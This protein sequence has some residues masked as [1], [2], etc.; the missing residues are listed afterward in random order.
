M[1]RV[2]RTIIE[3]GDDLDR[4]HGLL[5]SIIPFRTQDIGR[6][7]VD[8][9]LIVGIQ[10]LGIAVKLLR[11][12]DHILLALPWHIAVLIFAIARRGQRLMVVA[13]QAE[14]AARP[15]ELASIDVSASF[16]SA[17]FCAAVE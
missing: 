11:R 2:R 7:H 8:A 9:E 12:I 15:Q 5:H 13:V 4:W 14:L 16:A 1:Q 10:A 6:R 3:R 17:R